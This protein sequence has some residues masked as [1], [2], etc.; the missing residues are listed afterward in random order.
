MINDPSPSTDPLPVLPYGITPKP[1]PPTFNEAY[2]AP[3]YVALLQQLLAVML[4]KE[5]GASAIALRA[6]FLAACV[7]W[8]AVAAMLYVRGQ[9]K[10]VHRSDLFFMVLAYPMLAALA[11]ALRQLLE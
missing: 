5:T 1:T 10:S 6:I 9:D 2:R 7:Y 8:M 11:V 3:A 4:L